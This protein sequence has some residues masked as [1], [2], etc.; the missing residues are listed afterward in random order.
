MA[1]FASEAELETFLGRLDPD[2]SQF[3][4]T[5]WQN[6]VRTAR[7]L[8]NATKPLLLSYGLPE[9]YIDDINATADTT[10]ID[11]VDAETNETP[12]RSFKVPRNHQGKLF[13]DGIEKA[14]ANRGLVLLG[15]GEDVFPAHKDGWTMNTFN[16][17]P[18]QL[19]V[20]PKPGVRFVQAVAYPTQQTFLRQI[21]QAIVA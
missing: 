3:A 19:I 11:A 18:V 10:D 21:W 15:I 16:A 20:G 13:L 14:L 12:V 9:L 2:Y 7:Q 17:S 5:L 8:A 4:S 6:G 1:R